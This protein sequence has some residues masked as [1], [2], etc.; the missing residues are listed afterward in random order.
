MRKAAIF[1][2][3]AL[4]SLN[5]MLVNPV[6]A[7]EDSLVVKN[8]SVNIMPEYDTPE[9]LVLYTIDFTNKSEMPFNDEIRFRIPKETRNNTVI[10]TGS[11]NSE[12]LQV[13]TENNAEYA[14]MIW[15]PSK[16]LEPNTTYAIHLEYYYDSLPGIGE[17][18]FSFVLNPGFA[19]ENAQIYLAQPLKSVDFK[20]EPTTVSMQ[21]NAQG[22]K[23]Y[24]LN[25]GFLNQDDPFRVKVS[26]TKTNPNPS[27]QPANDLNQNGAG[28]D[29]NNRGSWAILLPLMAIFLFIIFI[30]YRALASRQMENDP[31]HRVFK[32]NEQRNQDLKKSPLVEEKRKLRQKLLK[33]EIDS[34]MYQQLLKDIE[35]DYHD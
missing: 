31:N 19:L 2:L 25:P 4:V 22:F 6:S 16:P 27:I 9:V 28:G 8:L 29:Q 21:T 26:Y 3:L 1:L 30:A 7:Q 20:T 10:E 17:K 18:T 32:S 33:N 14:E 23:V 5:L 24:R 15:K 11:Q 13:R 12:H 35:E 34:K